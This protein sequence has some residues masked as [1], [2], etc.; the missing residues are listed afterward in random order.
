MG[1]GHTLKSRVQIG[2]MWLLD[3][4]LVGLE[5]GERERNNTEEE[6]KE[7]AWCEL[8]EAPRQAGRQE[9]GSAGCWSFPSGGSGDR[10][11]GGGRRQELPSPPTT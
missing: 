2:V 11:S 1:G 3:R 9:V 5:S 6:E 4:V 7:K 8:G 10:D